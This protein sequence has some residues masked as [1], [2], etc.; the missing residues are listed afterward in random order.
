MWPIGWAAQPNTSVD[1]FNAFP[2]PD[3]LIYKHIT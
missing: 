1:L 3:S 2:M